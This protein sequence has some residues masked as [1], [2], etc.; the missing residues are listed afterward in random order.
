[1]IKIEV[2]KAHQAKIRAGYPWVF[3]YQVV[4]QKGTGVAGDLAVVYDHRNRFLAMGLYDPHSEIRLRV[5]QT[6]SPVEIDAEFF[7]TRFKEAQILRAG[8]ESQGTTGYRVLNGEGDGFPGLVLDRYDTTV[9]FKLYSLCWF[10]WLE[11]LLETIHH[12]APFERAVLRLSRNI[13]QAA[14][15][16]GNYRDG[17]VLSG[18]NV[19]EPVKFRENG[20]WFEADVLHGQKTGFFLDQRDNRGR[21]RLLAG[22]R[23]VANVFSYTGAFSVYAGVGGCR[24]VLE[25]DANPLAMKSARENWRLNG[26]VLGLDLKVP[27]QICGDAFEILD[28]LHKERRMFDLVILDPPAFARKKNQEQKALNAYTSLATSGAKVTQSN[29]LLFAASCSNQVGEDDFFEA[30]LRG[31]R[32]AGRKF[33]ERFRSGHAP[34]HPIRFSEGAYLKAICLELGV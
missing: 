20:L 32:A 5:L 4:A 23:R 30:S 31:I 8:L 6:R 34:D 22:G 26:S 1:M 13:H 17:Q 14:Q 19:D 12:S 33:S 2:S 9:V 16:A 7:R 3:H 29:G 24:S 27:E 15:K 28:R 18:P 25:I 21:I 11:T 10:P